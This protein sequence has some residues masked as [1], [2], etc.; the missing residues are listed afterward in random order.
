MVPPTTGDKIIG[1]GTLLRIACSAGVFF[2]RANDL[3]MKA[4]V[5]T[6]KEGRKWGES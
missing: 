4:H 6:R 3:L 2:R 5:E 1:L